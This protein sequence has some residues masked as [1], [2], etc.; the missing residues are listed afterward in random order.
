M[1]YIVIR[2]NQQQNAV[3]EEIVIRAFLS[4]SGVIADAVFYDESLQKEELGTRKCFLEFLQKLKEGDM[5]I[6]SKLETLS[7]RVGELVQILAKILEKQCEILCVESDEIVSATTHSGALIS[8]LSKVRT[9]NIKM[10]RGELGR[11]KGSRSRSKYDSHLPKIIE[12]LKTS[13]NISALARELNI[14]RTSLK[15]YIASRGL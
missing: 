14:S 9:Q 8:T 5:L 12:F 2:V 11:P 3:N 15:D 6:V 13:R 4:G 10:G 1:N 7:Y